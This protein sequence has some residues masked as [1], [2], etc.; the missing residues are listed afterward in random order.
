MQRSHDSVFLRYLEVPAAHRVKESLTG[1][2]VTDQVCLTPS[3]IEIAK[4]PGKKIRHGF[5]GSESKE[6]VILLTGGNGGGV[7]QGKLG[8][9]IG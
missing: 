8:P 4:R 7:L 2:L 3:S 5:V 6:Q 1:N 9:C